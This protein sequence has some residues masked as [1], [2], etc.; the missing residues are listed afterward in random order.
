MYTYIKKAL[1]VICLLTIPCMNSGVIAM[2]KDLEDNEHATLAYGLRGLQEESIIDS[3]NSWTFCGLSLVKRV[4]K[5]TTDLLSTI[6]NNNGKAILSVLTFNIAYATAC[7]CT[8]LADPV[9][10]SCLYIG[11]TSNN[12]TCSS[13][14]RSQGFLRNSI[15][16]NFLAYPEKSSAGTC[17]CTCL[18]EQALQTC[19]YIGILPDNTA[20]RNLCIG[21]G[22][23]KNSICPTY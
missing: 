3:Q 6:T 1:L 15:C 20:C 23:I 14:C 7:Y 10:R 9:Q 5:N 4:A 8:C 2:E 22:F 19:A 13:E 21:K 12:F 11:S 17:Y 16:T 18:P